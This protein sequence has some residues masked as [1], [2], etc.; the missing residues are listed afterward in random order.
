MTLLLAN[1]RYACRVLRRQPVFSSVAILTMALGIGATTAVFSVV[2]GLLL[3]PLPY[4][5]PGRLVMLMYGHQGRVSPWFSP[6][7]F[8]DYVHPEPG[9]LG[10]RSTRTEHREYHWPRGPGT[11]GRRESLVE[12]LR[13]PGRRD[14]TRRPFVEA[15]NQ[16][17]AIGSF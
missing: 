10:C 11:S 4:R 17:T 8:R 1:V 15:D 2:Y 14:G 9:L 16:A 12:L 3:R 5:D 13:H 6:L 7:N